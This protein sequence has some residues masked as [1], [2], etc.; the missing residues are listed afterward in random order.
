MPKQ[1]GMRILIINYEYPP[2]GGG[3]STA[4]AEMA[5]RAARAGHEV[6]VLT[7]RFA[8]LPRSELLNGHTVKRIPAV[9][10]SASKCT[11]PE[12]ITFIISAVPSAVRLAGSFRPDLV[13]AV[14]GIPSGPVALALNRLRGIRYIV[15]LRAAE[16]PGFLS[17][18]LAI[19]HRLSMPLTRAIWLNAAA[20]TTN[21]QGL[22]ELALKTTPELEID[23]I[24]NAVDTERFSPSGRRKPGR[25]VRVTFLGRLSPQ[26]GVSYLLDALSRMAPGP[27]RAFHLDVYGDGPE[28]KSLLRQAERLA[29][30]EKV[31][32]R[33]WIPRNKVPAVLRSSDVF[34]LPSLGEGMSNSLLE[35]MAT[36]LAVIATD[37]AGSEELIADGKNGLL[38]PPRDVPALE[39]A[40][41]RLIDS[42][43]LRHRLGAAAR[44]SALRNLSWE[45]VTRRYLDLS[46]KALRALS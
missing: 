38:I 18:K 30:T 31:T 45:A 41:V 44:E 35:A 11:V 19:Y 8:D 2:I 39:R 40:L 26:K 27:S 15:L 20:V 13:W 21:S 23:V 9:R 17:E 36:G 28:R 4:T 3:S 24:P 43:A 42:Q 14:N 34:V 16:V 10:L 29:L 12:M 25:S 6:T 33:G 46:Q 1:T 7:T 37:V 22:K 5:A 32:F